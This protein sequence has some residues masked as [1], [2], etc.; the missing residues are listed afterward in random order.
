[1]T[2]YLDRPEGRIGY[3]LTGEGPLVVCIPGMGDL[4]QSYRF[5]VPLLVAAGYRVAT[6]DLRGHGDSDDGFT[7]HDAVAA[8]EDAVALVEELGGAPAVL[9]G[10]SLGGGAAV[11]AAATAPRLV[12][13]LVLVDAFVR[14]GTTSAVMRLFYR[15]ALLKPWGPPFVGSFYRR[16]YPTRPP[17]DLAAH[18]SAI[19]AS[20][21]RGR[22]WSEFVATTRPGRTV[23]ARLADVS[24]PTLVLM[25]DRDGDFKDPVAEARWMAER[26][27]AELVLVPAAGHYPQAEYPELVGA[28]VT[29]FLGRVFQ[30]A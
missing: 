3:D 16:S 10:N 26:L 11:S 25:G 24:A 28:A 21:R 19:R 5:L 2:L 7:R 14:D 17:A 15:L 22:H 30:R 6:M 1:M 20:F 12:A 13:G 9:V 18:Q 8:G 27:S 29:G 4:R 23:E